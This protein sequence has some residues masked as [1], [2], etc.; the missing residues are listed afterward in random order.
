MTS[1]SL[2]QND[3]GT[4]IFIATLFTIAQTWKQLKSPSTDEQIKKMWYMYIYTHTMD[5]SSA[6]KKKNFAICSNMDGLERHILHH[7]QFPSFDVI[8]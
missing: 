5:Y 6:M 2:T 8:P 3:T 7:C 1:K 4:V